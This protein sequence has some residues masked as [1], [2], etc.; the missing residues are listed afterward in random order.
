MMSLPHTRSS[1]SMLATGVLFLLL[2]VPAKAT[3]PDRFTPASRL[4]PID[5][6]KAD[7]PPTVIT[8]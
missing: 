3:E 4:T 1:A 7:L 5:P 2:G 6:A 8:Q